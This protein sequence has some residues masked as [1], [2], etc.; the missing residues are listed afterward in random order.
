MDTRSRRW[1]ALGFAAIVVVAVVVL[2]VARMRPAAAAD[3]PRGFETIQVGSLTVTRDP[4][5]TLATL[6]VR[7]GIKVVCAVAYGETT[8]YGHLATT[9]S[10]GPAGTFD[11]TPVLTGLRPG[12]TYVYRIQGVGAD[13]RLYRS[14]VFSFRTPAATASLPG[15]NVALGATVL[16]V[17]SAYSP[18][19]VGKNAVD[20]DPATEWSSNGDG[21]HAFITID[22]HRAVR[23][24]AVAFRTRSMSDGSAI[25]RTFSVTVDGKKTYGPFP[26]LPAPAVNRVAFAGRIL[27]FNV[28]RS[29]GGNTGASEIAV[30]A[31]Q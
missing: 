4:S 16:Q 31:G 6:R 22:L 28:V 5:G 15:R 20:G 24:I 26:A 2:L 21:N 3:Q 19:Y 12:I 11:H 8:A 30:Y 29:T 17:S 10:M 18:D 13:G 27:R 23:V 1:A 14:P 9:R 25:T 7:T